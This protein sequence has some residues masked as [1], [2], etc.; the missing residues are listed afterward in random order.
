MSN[1]M[2]MP[3]ML[4][5]ILSG[6]AKVEQMMADQNAKQN[7][8]AEEMLQ[9]LEANLAKMDAWTKEMKDWRRVSMACQET[10]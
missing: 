4:E 2:E 9:R 8:M 6:Q 10:T 5:R 3:Q 1:I 7:Q